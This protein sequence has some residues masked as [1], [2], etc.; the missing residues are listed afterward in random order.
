MAQMFIMFINIMFYIQ[1]KRVA[2]EAKALLLNVPSVMS[3]SDFVYR[4]VIW[5]NLLKLRCKLI[6]SRGINRFWKANILRESTVCWR[7]S[8]QQKLRHK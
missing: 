3:D 4:L 7:H 5:F 2:L 1:Y 6:V 8:Q